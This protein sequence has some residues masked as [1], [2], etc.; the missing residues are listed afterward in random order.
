MATYN[1][2]RF[3]R[4]QLDRLARQTVLPAELVIT[5][6][7]SSDNTLEI[8]ADFAAQAPFPVRVERNPENL[9]YRANFM[10]AAGL[11]TSDLIAFCDQDD[12]WLP[13]KLE[14]CLKLF[15]K[16]DVLLV[17]H[18]ATV[19]DEGLNAIG[20]LEQYKPPHALNPPLSLSPRSLAPGFT[21]ILKSTL[22]S[23]NSLW[24]QS[25]DPFDRTQTEPH[26]KWF[27]FLAASLGTIGYVDEPLALYRR[28]G[29]NLTNWR[30][31][32]SVGA[33]I[34]NLLSTSIEGLAAQEES[35]RG[36]SIALAQTPPSI[37]L[38]GTKGSSRYT[39][40]AE[41][42]HKRRDM[43]QTQGL[44]QRLRLLI[45]LARSGCYRPQTQWG[46]GQK[47]IVRDFFSVIC[48]RTS[49]TAT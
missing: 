35:A 23:F 46:V 33:K 42:Y 9:G 6:D 2:A 39:N 21:E 41:F 34:R 31:P 47:A 11:C 48:F 29:S 37:L 15:E 8:V 1:G 20:R 25:R 30:E 19:V 14:T 7:G 12:I 43:Y 49:G 13:H 5:D 16:D 4:E 22:L 18:D 24:S 38:D 28:H 32:S 36:R 45:G 44:L 10:K 26:D 3:I 40:L 17:H 27:F